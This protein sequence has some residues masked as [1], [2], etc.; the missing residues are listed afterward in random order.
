MCRGKCHPLEGS[1]WRF[2]RRRAAGTGPEA[3]EVLRATPLRVAPS[4]VRAPPAPFRAQP[5]RV[6]QQRASRRLLARQATIP[7]CP[8]V[9]CWVLQEALA[10]PRSSA[11]PPLRLQLQG[12]QRPMPEVEAAIAA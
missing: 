1:H 7:C 10:T 8:E 3:R 6:Q 5:A 2:R 11:A 9:M 4:L 12:R